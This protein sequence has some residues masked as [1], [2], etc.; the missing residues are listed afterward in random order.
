MTPN[1]PILFQSFFMIALVVVAVT[2]AVIAFVV[3]CSVLITAGKPDGVKRALRTLGVVSALVVPAVAVV[4]LVGWGVAVRTR[5]LPADKVVR[6]VT[7]QGVQVRVST[8]SANRSTKQASRTT[9]MRLVS[10]DDDAALRSATTPTID[11]VEVE[12]PASATPPLAPVAP[13][14]SPIPP[15]EP[16][17]LDTDVEVASKPSESTGLVATVNLDHSR[18]ASEV[19]HVEKVIPMKPDWAGQ[20]EPHLGDRGPVVALSSGLWSS[21]GETEEEITRLARKFVA[22]FYHDQYPLANGQEIPISLIR[23]EAVEY[24]QG[25]EVEK[26]FGAGITGKMYRAHLKLHLTPDLKNG[27]AAFWKAQSVDQ[28][29]VGLGSGLGVLTAFLAAVAGYFRLNESTNGRYRGRLKLAALAL[30]GAVG[31]LCLVA[32]RIGSIHIN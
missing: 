17:I 28:K 24:L 7:P 21:M 18:P 1:V 13:P 4:V 20:T 29:L 6:E 16:R 31:L 25:E 27:V 23:D 8:S 32:L 11:I 15:T 5:P 22:D 2:L 14:G 10:Q 12:D 9:K 26:D 19:L 3:I 30:V